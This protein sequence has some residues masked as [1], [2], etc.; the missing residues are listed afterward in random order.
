VF[1]VSQHHKY[2]PDPSRVIQ[3]DEVQVR[4]N[5]IVDALS[6]RIED[7]EVKNFR[8]TEIALVTVT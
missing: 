4:D 2:V 5:L 7:R 8:G 6:L 1:H 3:M